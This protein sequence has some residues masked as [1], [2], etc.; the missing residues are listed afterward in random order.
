MEFDEEIKD[1]S[2]EYFDERELTGS[3]S[4]GP[5]DPVAIKFKTDKSDEAAPNMP[6]SSSVQRI[7]RIKLSKGSRD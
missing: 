2:F 3:E 5:H 7:S 1:R 6:I 4:Y